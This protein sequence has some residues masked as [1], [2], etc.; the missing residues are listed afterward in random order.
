KTAGRHAVGE[1]V[2]FLN[3]RAHGW[4]SGYQP[5]DPGD[6]DDFECLSNAPADAVFEALEYKSAHADLP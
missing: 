3:K 2:A 5:D 1:L 4:D 6:E